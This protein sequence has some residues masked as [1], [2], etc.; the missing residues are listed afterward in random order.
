MADIA[1][2]NQQMKKKVAKKYRYAHSAAGVH[3]VQRL[4][5][6]GFS[7]SSS[8][9]NGEALLTRSS[10]VCDEKAVALLLKFGAEINRVD[11]TGDTPLC[12][13]L[14]SAVQQ[15]EPLAGASVKLIDAML[16]QHGADVNF[17]R[18]AAKWPRMRSLESPLIALVEEQPARDHERLHTCES[19]RMSAL[20]IL[21]AAGAM[22]ETVRKIICL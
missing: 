3:E 21:L 8:F 9:E 20:K 1:E 4:L 18:G 12:A 15:T 16:S 2:K 22:T 10:S 13:A 17:A 6:A 19:A 5:A 7:A 11:A 14:V